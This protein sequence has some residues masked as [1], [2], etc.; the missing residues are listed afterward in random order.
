MNGRFEGHTVVITGVNDRGI[1]GA[2]ARRFAE[3]GASLALLWHE[4]PNRLLKLMGKRQDDVLEIPC[5]VTQQECVD[6][7]IDS[8]VQ[9]FGKI[10]I[11]VNNA[12][13]DHSGCLEDLADEDWSRVIDV[14]LTG[15]M[16]MI[17]SCLPHITEGSGAIVNLAS[18]LGLAGCGGFPAYS[19]TKAGMIGLA[20]SLAMELAPRGIRAVCVAPA[21]VMSPMTHK[22]LTSL[23]EN[24]DQELAKSHPLGPGT[25]QDV[26]AAVAFVASQEARWITGITLPLGWSAAFPLP[27]QQF[28]VPRQK[29]ND[30]GEL[31]NQAQVNDSFSDD[32]DGILPMRAA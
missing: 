9:R 21:L 3:E 16:R 2:I 22:Y 7:S 29:R 24:F 17:R 4:R 28:L 15:A 19:A 26:A 8:I 30:A 11:L 20:Q 18:V 1:G 6:A 13:I 32:D 27:M 12:G 23:D 14:N 25:P 31:K 10:D 5:D